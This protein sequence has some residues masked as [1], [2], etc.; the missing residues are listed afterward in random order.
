MRKDSL[1]VLRRTFDNAKRGFCECAK[2]EGLTHT[3]LFASYIWNC[4]VKDWTSMVRQEITGSVGLTGSAE[5]IADDTR[6]QLVIALPG[7]IVSTHAMDEF[8]QAV[9]DDE[10]IVERVDTRILPW[11]NIKRK[12]VERR[13]MVR[14]I[15]QKHEGKQ[16]CMFGF[17]QGGQHAHSIGAKY[18]IPSVSFG[19]P[20]NSDATPA[21]YVMAY[22]GQ[23]TG[24]SQPTIPNGAI[25][26]AE[27]FSVANPF[28]DDGVEQMNG[29]HSHFPINRPEVSQRVIERI[30]QAM[31]AHYGK[32]A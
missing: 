18:N 17:S 1:D 28:A 3:Q 30:N 25:Q 7:F 4:F 8:L 24:N 11:H 26:M 2:R 14:E 5:S 10:K 23:S 15:L 31:A 6:D 20:V 21:G 13:R 9:E 22:Y 29:I 12:A 19:M 27:S 16:V 32:P